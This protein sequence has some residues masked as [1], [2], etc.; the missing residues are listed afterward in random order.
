MDFNHVIATL[1][2]NGRDFSTFHSDKTREIAADSVIA[3]ISLRQSVPWSCGLPPQA[4][5]VM[6]RCQ[7]RLAPCSASGRLYQ[8]RIRRPPESKSIGPRVSLIFRSIDTCV[9]CFTIER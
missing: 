1:Y 5:D 8:H 2:L 3:T 6:N 9:P 4:Q 7:W